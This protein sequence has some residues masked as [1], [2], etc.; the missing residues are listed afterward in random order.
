[1]A[2]KQKKNAGW[3]TIVAGGTAGA[4]DCC[5]TMPLDTIGTQIQLQGYRGPIECAKAIGAYP[6]HS[7]IA[8]AA[9]AISLAFLRWFDAHSGRQWSWWTVRW[10]RAVLAAVFSQVFHTFFWF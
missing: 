9:L 1:M 8:A 10:L 3:R 7:P 6:P 5:I 2:A 4:I